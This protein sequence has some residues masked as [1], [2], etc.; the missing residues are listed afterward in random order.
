MIKKNGKLG[1]EGNF[2][3]LIRK[4]LKKTYRKK[5]NKN[6]AGKLALSDIKTYSKTIA[7]KTVQC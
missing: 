3:T 7:M 4:L 1:I 2:L 6:K 5:I